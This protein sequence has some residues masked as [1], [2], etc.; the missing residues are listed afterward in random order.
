MSQKQ[1]A[2]EDM[3]IARGWTAAE[4][5]N[6]RTLVRLAVEEDLNRAGD[7]TSNALIPVSALGVVEVV[8]RQPGVVAGLPI[9]SLVY[10]QLDAK[11]HAEFLAEEGARVDSGQVLAR[12]FGPVRSLLTGERTALNFVQ[13]LCGVAT[14]T[15][16]FVDA[17]DG[18]RAVILDTRKTTPGWRRLEKYAVRCGGG[19]NHRGGL[20]D[21]ILIKD[22]H[23]AFIDA[24]GDPVEAAVR[25]ARSASPPGTHVEIEVD[26]L[27]QLDHALAAR[28]DAILLDNMTPPELTEAVRRRNVLAPSVRLEASGG[29]TLDTVRQVAETGVDFISIGA[30]TH[31]APVLDIAVDYTT[32]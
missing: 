27:D 18:L 22:N 30:L 28:P 4:A 6:A 14:L 5:D 8:A 13:R 16:R 3:F 7:L 19:R 11:V 26:T 12:L 32:K 23:L 17:V 21:R 1:A 15:R 24:E 2:Y 10:A 31:S 9:I 25:R 29:I 20:F